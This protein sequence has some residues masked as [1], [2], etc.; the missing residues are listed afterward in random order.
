MPREAAQ[1]RAPPGINPEHR[2]PNGIALDTSSDTPI[3]PL[4]QGNH[5]MLPRKRNDQHPRVSAMTT[6]LFRKCDSIQG[7]IRGKQQPSPVK[8]ARQRSYP[9]AKST[10]R[11]SP[12]AFN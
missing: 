7:D 5:Q 11:L 8:P 9:R 12:S 1:K 10:P 6:L 4:T 2:C 3:R